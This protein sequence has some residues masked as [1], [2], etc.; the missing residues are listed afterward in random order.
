MRFFGALAC[1]AAAVNANGIHDANGKIIEGLAPEELAVGMPGSLSDTTPSIPLYRDS[2][3]TESPP[4]TLPIDR[5][6]NTTA[7]PVE[8][9]INVH[10]T[11]HTHDDTGWQVCLKEI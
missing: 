4:Y 2:G 7:G 5:V 8:G 6:Y 11:P 10:L 3:K 9:K 1:L